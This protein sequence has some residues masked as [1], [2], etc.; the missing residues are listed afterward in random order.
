LISKRVCDFVS[1]GL[2]AQ[3]ASEAALHILVERVN[4]VGGLI[5]VDRSGRIGV[6]YNTIA[7]PHAF[8]VDREEVVS[9]D[10]RSGPAD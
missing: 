10:R 7:M 4:G 9:S 5:A 2:P 3:K 1:Q 8:A 6:V